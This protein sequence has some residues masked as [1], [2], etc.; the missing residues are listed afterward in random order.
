MDT[1]RNKMKNALTSHNTD[2]IVEILSESEPYG[3]SMA[4]WRLALE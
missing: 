3:E 1:M 4:R 2:K